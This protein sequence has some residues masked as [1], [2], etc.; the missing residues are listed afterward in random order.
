MSSAAERYYIILRYNTVCRQFI[1]E[2]KNEKEEEAR[3]RKR[4]RKKEK[5]KKKRRRKK[6]EEVVEEEKKKKRRYF[7]YFLFLIHILNC[8]LFHALHLRYV[9]FICMPVPIVA[10]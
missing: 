4:R 5:K 3:R 2:K 7:L 8:K 6:K 9:Y 1:R 10:N